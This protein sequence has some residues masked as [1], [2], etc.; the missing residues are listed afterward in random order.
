VQVGE[1]QHEVPGV[2]SLVQPLVGLRILCWD[3]MIFQMIFLPLK[4][5]FH[6]IFPTLLSFLRVGA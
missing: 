5:F 1:L 2:H 3:L 4:S 6:T